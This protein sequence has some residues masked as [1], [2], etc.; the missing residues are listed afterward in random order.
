MAHKHPRQS[1][2]RS[3]ERVRANAVFE[4]MLR[5]A[6]NAAI[7]QTGAPAGLRQIIHDAGADVFDIVEKHI[8]A[9]AIPEAQWLV[10]QFVAK[11]LANCGFTLPV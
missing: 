2:A 5:D 11:A 10:A 4:Q 8:T 1:L 7:E 9:G 6:T 3:I